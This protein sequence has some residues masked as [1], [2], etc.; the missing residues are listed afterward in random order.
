MF[1]QQ[2]LLS[3]DAVNNMRKES[4]RT[5]FNHT[6]S[7]TELGLTFRPIEETIRDEVNWFRS[8]GLLEGETL[9]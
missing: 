8:A 1:G 4:F 2:V 3:M 7:E 6:K 9:G 5:R